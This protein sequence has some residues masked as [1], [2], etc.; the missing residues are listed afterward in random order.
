MVTFNSF[1]W[2]LLANFSKFL[3]TF[4][5]FYPLWTASAALGHFWTFLTAFGHFWSLCSHFGPL[6]TNSVDKRHSLD[7]PLKGHCF[8]WLAEAFYG[9]HCCTYCI[10]S[11]TFTCKRWSASGR[12]W[13]ALIRTTTYGGPEN[14]K[15]LCVPPH[16]GHAPPAGTGPDWELN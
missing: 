7:C 11:L 14:H 6:G 13:S 10:S 16:R 9:A 2:S 8:S 3:A 12:P 5:F 4:G 1:F 15:K